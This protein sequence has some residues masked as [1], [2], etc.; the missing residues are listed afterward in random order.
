MKLKQPAE[1]D[2]EVSRL[3]NANKKKL[4][5]E[6]AKNRRKLNQTQFHYA[7]TGKRRLPRKN[8]PASLVKECINLMKLKRKK[9]TCMLMLMK[10]MTVSN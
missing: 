9:F 1:S 10:Y 5:L 3:G 4:T 7:E 8:N 6:P 2:S